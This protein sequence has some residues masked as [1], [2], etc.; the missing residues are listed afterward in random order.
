[1]KN[2]ILKTLIITVTIGSSIHT[3]PALKTL[4]LTASALTGA[5]AGH[6]LTKEMSDDIKRKDY[7]SAAEITA[8]ATAGAATM[9]VSGVG[10]KLYGETLTVCVPQP[11]APGIETYAYKVGQSSI[12]FARSMRLGS[13]GMLIGA[14]ATLAY[15]LY[16]AAKNNLCDPEKALKPLD[17]HAE[18]LKAHQKLMKNK[19]SQ[20]F[21]TTFKLAHN[22]QRMLI[23]NK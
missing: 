1:M 21:A 11:A 20:W 8:Y 17:W 15:Q 4:G 6:Y 9:A 2:T 14:L 3:I 5:A 13:R 7:T 12:N 18:E 10:M 22:D 23:G 19:A 16:P